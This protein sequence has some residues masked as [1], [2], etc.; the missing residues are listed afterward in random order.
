M[1]AMSRRRFLAAAAAAPLAAVR[2][3]WTG[4]TRRV[5]RAD[6]GF[7]VPAA[8]VRGDSSV[9]SA[10]RAGFQ[11]RPGGAKGHDAVERT[12]R[13][14]AAA[15][16]YLRDR[17]A[18]LRRHFVFE[19]YPWY[20][21]NPFRHWDDPGLNPPVDIAARSMPLLGPYDSR[22]RTTL[23]RHARWMAD[24]G[25]GAINMSWWGRD[26]FEDRAVPFVM[27]VMRAHDIHVT[28]HLEPY[29]D[30]RATR[31]ASDIMYLLREYGERRRWDAFLLLQD[32]S[33][34]EG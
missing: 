16:E 22:D 14:P 26:S 18:D 28:F 24:A 30:D 17:F 1:F 3:S 25:V 33:G 12:L 19:Y 8:R 23:E 2:P 27:D 29:A 6:L 13:T 15:F 34:A 7:P 10:I 20:G 31:Y 5:S 9:G 4:R 21:V 32:G 11:L